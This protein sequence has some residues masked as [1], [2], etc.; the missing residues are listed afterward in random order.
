MEVFSIFATLSL[1]DLVSGPL[2]RIRGAMGGVN[3]SV[4]SLGQR[5]G[6]LA[7]AMAP[8]ALAAGAMIGAFGAA[9]SR[10][11]AFESAMADVRK[12]VNFAAETHVD[13]SIKDSGPF[14][15]SNIL[16]TASLLDAVNAFHVRRFHQIST[17]EV[18]GDLPIESR[19]S[20]NENSRLSP[21]NP[22]S[23]SKASADMIALSYCRTYGTPVTISR[24]VNN[25]GPFQNAEKLIPLSITRV[26]NHQAVPVYAK[27]ENV[28]SWI[29]VDDHSRAV[30][31]I[32]LKGRTG[33]VYNISS[34]F[35]ISNI[36]IVRYIIAKMGRNEDQI[37]FVP[38]RPGH[39]RRYSLENNKIVS[40][41]SLSSFVPF[42]KALDQTIDW[43]LRRL[44][45]GR[46]CI[47]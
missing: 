28:R 20:F 30:E 3:A 46:N 25:Y 43:Y 7:L 14:F 35:E 26:F 2:D 1:V 4:A 9:A 21:S 32:L 12:V 17:D 41:L 22:Y 23:A 11:M 47:L 8:V 29:Y 45:D 6:N 40:E 15:T 18:Y 38:D 36:E 42:F 19:E 33:E 16:G 10:A 5:M 13:N 34:G 27:G 39:D 44:E 31:S 37:T 24:S